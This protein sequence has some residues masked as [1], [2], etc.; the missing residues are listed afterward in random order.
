MYIVPDDKSERLMRE[1]GNFSSTLIN[2]E[3]TRNGDVEEGKVAS[4]RETSSN[5]LRNDLIPANI[6]HAKSNRTLST[7]N[8]ASRNEEINSYNNKGFLTIRQNGKWGKLC[9]KKSD[10]NDF[11]EAQRSTLSTEDLARSACKAI[12]YQ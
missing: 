4:S 5:I 10:T 8:A 11:S 3:L 9:L 7:A 1:K 2:Q 12:T 6:L